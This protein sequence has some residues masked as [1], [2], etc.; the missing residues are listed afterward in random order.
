MEYPDLSKTYG[1]LNPKLL[2]MCERMIIR[3]PSDKKPI[4]KVLD[5]ITKQSYF[6]PF[7]NPP[8]EFMVENYDKKYI[9]FTNG[10]YFIEMAEKKGKYVVELESCYFKKGKLQFPIKKTRKT[11][12]NIFEAIFE[13]FMLNGMLEGDYFEK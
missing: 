11:Y 6:F 2:R 4:L 5:E 9:L 1:R 13:V 7:S 8:H 12:T 3:K 10:V